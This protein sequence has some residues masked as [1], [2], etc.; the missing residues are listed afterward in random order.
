MQVN[1]H[2]F[3][4]EVASEKNEVRLPFSGR[5]PHKPKAKR[6]GERLPTRIFQGHLVLVLGRILLVFILTFLGTYF[7]L[8]MD[9][10]SDL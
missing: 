10:F 2:G 5:K 4:G 6:K 9:E 3:Y 1:I 8:K 7:L